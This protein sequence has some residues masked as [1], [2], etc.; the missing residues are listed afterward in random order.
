VG[1]PGRSEL[2]E[3]VRLAREMLRRKQA[4]TKTEK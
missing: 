4:G 2:W 1:L 3:R